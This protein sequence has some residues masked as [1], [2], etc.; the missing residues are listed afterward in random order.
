[1]SILKEKRWSSGKE[2]VNAVKLYACQ[3]SKYAMVHTRGRM[4]RKLVCSSA[5]VGCTWFVNISRI[6][7]C[8]VGY[9][10]VTS[11]RLSHVNCIQRSKLAQNQLSA[12]PVIRSALAANP[13]SAARK[14]VIQ[15]R[16][17]DGLEASRSTI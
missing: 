14:L 13:S 3:Q 9:W 7:K 16:H 15:L 1:M 12:H 17:E 4:S 11:S 6:R 2:A 8:D 10:H 5:D